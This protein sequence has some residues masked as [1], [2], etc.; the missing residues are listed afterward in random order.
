[1]FLLN[2]LLLIDIPSGFHKLNIIL[3]HFSFFFSV[4]LLLGAMPYEN[5]TPELFT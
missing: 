2:N 3:T 1:M 4:C 5:S